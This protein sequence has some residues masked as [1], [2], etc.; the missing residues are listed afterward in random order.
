MYFVSYSLPSMSSHGR[1]SSPGSPDLTVPRADQEAFTLD[2]E[3]D[4]SELWD[5][6]SSSDSCLSEAFLSEIMPELRRIEGSSRL[7]S[8][9]NPLYP[10]P[11]DPEEF[12]RLDKQH[13]LIKLGLWG[14]P[15]LRNSIESVLS[16]DPGVPKAVLDIGCGSGRWALDMATEHENLRV[17]AIDVT[18]HITAQLPP[19]VV[20]QHYNVNDGLAPYYGKYD[21]VHVRC[22][23]S[24]I[25]SYRGLLE[26]ASKCLKPGGLAIFM[27]GDF[28]LWS[29][30]RRSLQV[31]ASDENPNGSWLQRWMQ[32]VRMAQVRRCKITESDNSPETLDKGL[33]QFG[34]YDENTCG[35]A[36]IYT[37]ISPWVQSDIPEEQVHYRITGVL[38]RQNLKLFV[39]SSAQTLMDDG[40]TRE[41]TE[42]W[43][44][45]IRDELQSMEIKMW[46]RWRIAWGRMPSEKSK[47]SSSLSGSKP[48]RISTMARQT[49]RDEL[50]EKVPFFHKKQCIHYTSKGQALQN[51][52]FL[53]SLPYSTRGRF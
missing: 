3:S 15:S 32:A 34:C 20:Y 53:N 22:V 14:L 42:E 52:N 51:A 39:N 48:R 27:E 4:C 17:D 36:G 11:L 43:K 50:R 9:Q 16:K 44:L 33:W 45:R 40:M 10:L 41:E 47:H 1:S 19:N 7:F 5:A 6:L 28:D 2:T 21:I 25:M 12:H 35:V 38:M 46:K 26:E 23:G 13:T 8:A 49:A 30:D 18:S 29:E 31:P 24:G 37:P